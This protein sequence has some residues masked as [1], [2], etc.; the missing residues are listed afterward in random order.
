MIA[1]SDVFVDRMSAIAVSSLLVIA[2]SRFGQHRG[3][4]KPSHRSLRG[5][6]SW[7]NIDA[8]VAINISCFSEERC[9]AAV[10]CPQAAM[11][12]MHTRRGRSRRVAFLPVSVKA[13]PA[14]STIL[15][16]FT[17]QS[18]VTSPGQ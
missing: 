10:V 9:A 16:S 7:D 3:E 17:Q 6:K 15:A 11:A 5:C 8:G 18:A 1:S 2:D 12:C 14:V 13:L 4:P